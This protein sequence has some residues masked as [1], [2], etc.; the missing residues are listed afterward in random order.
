M[1]TVTERRSI[2]AMMGGAKCTQKSHAGDAGDKQDP[3]QTGPRTPALPATACVLPTQQD[4]SES[5]PFSYF[6][7]LRRQSFQKQSQKNVPRY[8]VPFLRIFLSAC[9]IPCLW[10]SRCCLASTSCMVGSGQAID[11]GRLGNWGAG[12]EKE[13]TKTTRCDVS[14]RSAHAR[15]IL[16]SCSPSLH[17]WGET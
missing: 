14:P 15:M 3:Q 2:R 10:E 6:T 8:L 12:R 1:I 9:A 11:L 7:A 4:S 5:N 17:P 13:K 16:S